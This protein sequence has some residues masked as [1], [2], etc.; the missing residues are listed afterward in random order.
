MTLVYL[1]YYILIKII[2]NLTYKRDMREYLYTLYLFGSVFQT[3]DITS[4]IKVAIDILA[5]AG[6]IRYFKNN[7]YF[8]LY[9][10]LLRFFYLRFN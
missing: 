9:S 3:M 5:R 2:V 6:V 7:D 4:I 8:G 1:V 10:S